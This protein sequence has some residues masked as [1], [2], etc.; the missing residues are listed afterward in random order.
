MRGPSIIITQITHDMYA[1][2]L[3]L[4]SFAVIGREQQQN[5]FKCRHHA[6]RMHKLK[7]ETRNDPS[8]N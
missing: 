6:A 7:G 8:K 1:Q 5:T 4:H 3:V 2:E